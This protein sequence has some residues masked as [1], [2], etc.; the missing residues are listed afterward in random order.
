MRE[1]RAWQV[2]A[3]EYLVQKP[4]LRLRQDRVRTGRGTTIDE[5]HVLEVPTWA[6]VCCIAE[7]GQLVLIRQYRHGIGQLTLELPAGVIEPNE[8]PLQGAQRELFEETGYTSDDWS[9]LATFA[10]EPARHTHL[11]H[12]F[13]A[14]GAKHTSQQSLDELEDLVVETFPASELMQ[15]IE[16]GAITH[17]V[18]VAALLLAQQRG[19]FQA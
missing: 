9:A 13:L 19:L 18:H 1:I 11:A 7:D 5:F 12:C 6:C 10:P 15:L 17:A 3:S 14:R 8:T 2:L 16:T 4:W